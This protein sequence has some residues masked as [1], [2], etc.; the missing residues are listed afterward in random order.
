MMKPVAA[1]LALLAFAVMSIAICWQR[2]GAITQDEL[3]RRTREIYDAVALGDP[4]PIDKY[5]AID[6]MI[7]DECPRRSAGR[8]PAV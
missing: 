7:F 8:K 6:S 1:P 2:P 4:G 5:F 3:V